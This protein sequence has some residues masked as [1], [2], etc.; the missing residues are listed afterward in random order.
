MAASFFFYDLETTGISSSRD[1]IM[2]FAGMRTDLD[3]VPIG[4]AYNIKLKISPDILPQPEAIMLT[5]ILPD[6]NNRDGISEAE[7]SGIFNT[8]ISIADTIFVGFNNIRFDDE[9][10]RYTNYR[11]FFDPYIWHWADG[12]SRWDLLD[13]VRM[14][15][16]LRPDGISW[17][18]VDGK[19][20]NKLELLTK[21]NKLDH[22]S[23]HDALSDVLATIELAKLIKNKQPKLFNYLL[24]LRTKEKSKDILS[25]TDPFVY[26]SSHYPSSYLHTSAAATLSYDHAKSTATVFDLRYDPNKYINLDPEKLAG[27]WAYDK[28]KL[29]SERLPIKTIKVNRCPA[30]APLSVLDPSSLKRL[31]LNKKTISANYSTLQKHKKA[32]TNKLNEV[33]KILDKTQDERLKA[34]VPLGPKADIQLYDNFIPKNDQAKFPA[35]RIQALKSHLDMPDF[36]DSRLEE[37]FKLYRARNYPSLLDKDEI[38]WWKKQV[39]NKLFTAIDDQDSSYNQYIQKLE[40]LKLDNKNNLSKLKVIEELEKYAK[41]TADDYGDD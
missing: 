14:T 9:F 32:F 3:L 5:G 17:P 40:L 2:Q 6:K 22:K 8:E 25:S 35:A 19:P 4:G 13:V 29:P 7:F 37:L 23:A 28:N 15:R 31:D 39:K 20:V 11:N 16:A 26:T 33:I 36:T 21:V 12:N 24:K 18:E 27:L 30:I 1:R 10:I 41:T 38:V 34:R